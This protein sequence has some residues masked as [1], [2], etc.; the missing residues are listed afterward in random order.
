MGSGTVQNP[1]RVQDFLFG[2]NQ[3]VATPTI[4]LPKGGG[5]VRVIGEK[6]LRIQLLVLAPCQYL[7]T[8]TLK[9]TCRAS[10]RWTSTAGIEL[11]HRRFIGMQVV[12]LPYFLAQAIREWSKGKKNLLHLQ[13]ETLHTPTHVDGI[14][15]QKYLLGSNHRNQPCSH[16]RRKAAFATAHSP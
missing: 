14:N 12:L 9:L 4:Q 15:Q 2:N 16:S 3:V 13:R 1:D 5:T 7:L 8:P 10:F 6:L 11:L